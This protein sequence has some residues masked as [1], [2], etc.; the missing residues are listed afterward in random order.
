MYPHTSLLYKLTDKTSY[1][2]DDYN[3]YRIADGFAKCMVGDTSGYAEVD[4]ADGDMKALARQVLRRA[5]DEG[6]SADDMT[7]LAVRVDVRA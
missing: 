1:I 7:V 3:Y 2:V 6:G 5:A 4:E